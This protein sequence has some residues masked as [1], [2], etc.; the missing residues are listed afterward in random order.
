MSKLLQWSGEAINYFDFRIYNT[1]Q[2]NQRGLAEC[3][4]PNYRPPSMPQ[5]LGDKIRSY[6][7]Y[8]VPTFSPQVE[9]NISR[10]RPS[11]SHSRPRSR[12]PKRHR[13]RH[14]LSPSHLST[15]ASGIFHTISHSSDPRIGTSSSDHHLTSTSS[16]TSRFAP[17][18]PP[19]SSTTQ[20]SSYT[21]N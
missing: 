5:L 13:P 15:N 18:P 1:A 9:R 4:N 8:T 10:H 19:T 14:L 7:G 6:L 11:H 12:S 16:H 21:Y 20:L 3:L 2:L 17:V